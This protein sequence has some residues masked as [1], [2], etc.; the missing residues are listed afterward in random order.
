MEERARQDLFQCCLKVVPA[1]VDS[2][3]Y[4]L[5]LHL[6]VPQPVE[7]CYL[8]ETWYQSG[9]FLNV[10]YDNVRLS[11]RF[12]I[13]G[14]TKRQQYPR[15]QLNHI[16]YIVYHPT[17]TNTSSP[18]RGQRIAPLHVDVLPLPRILKNIREHIKM[19]T[20]RHTGGF[21]R[22]FKKRRRLSLYLI[23]QI[24]FCRTV[25]PSLTLDR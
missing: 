18:P 4:T 7:R 20:L 9:W 23:L 5:T 13:V 2:M 6:H 16:V 19:R 1:S 14:A 8:M 22:K 17:I 3:L 15:S 10:V 11:C 24:I 12:S 25:W 21:V